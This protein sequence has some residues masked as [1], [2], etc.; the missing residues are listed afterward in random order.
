MSRLLEGQQEEHVEVTIDKPNV[1]TRV[2]VALWHDLPDRA[3]IHSVAVGS[4]ASEPMDDG[5]PKLVPF[6]EILTVNGIA[7]E[8]AIHAVTMIRNAESVVVIRKLPCPP[9][10]MH[11]AAALQHQWKVTLKRQQGLEQQRVELHKPEQT[12]LLGIS[13]S[14]EL[15]FA[16]VVKTVNASGPAAGV[17]FEGDRVLRING[18]P[19]DEPASAA[20]L[21]RSASGVIE[22][23]VQPAA[24]VDFQGLR[25]RERSDMGEEDDGEEESEED[26]GEE[27][28]ESEES[29]EEFYSDERVDGDE[30]TGGIPGIPRPKPVS[31]PPL[32]TTCVPTRRAPAE[33]VATSPSPTLRPSPKG[34]PT[35]STRAIAAQGGGAPRRL[36]EAGGWKEWLRQRRAMSTAVT[37]PAPSSSALP[38]K[39]IDQRV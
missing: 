19:C 14:P 23:V 18:E 20:K 13:F 33:L 27:G 6:D 29:E 7:C 5:S 38:S 26:S 21:L 2:G 4:P 39:T 28:E 25:A 17:L 3:V 36:Y 30:T 12:T 15:L 1:S 8:S 24:S 32:A 22:L 10:L 31:A 34:N 9:R 11:A 35:S 16:S 37:V